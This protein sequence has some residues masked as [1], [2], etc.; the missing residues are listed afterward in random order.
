MDF[1]D[2]AFIPNF[3]LGFVKTV[4]DCIVRKR[5]QYLKSGNI[6]IIQG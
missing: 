2:V 1:H 4:M 6:P 3:T 5:S